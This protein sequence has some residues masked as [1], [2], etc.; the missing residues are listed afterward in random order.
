MAKR[1][2]LQQLFDAINAE[3]AHATADRADEAEVA[4]WM[5]EQGFH[6]NTWTQ[7]ITEAEEVALQSAVTA[8]E[9]RIKEIVGGDCSIYVRI[10]SDATPSD[11]SALDTPDTV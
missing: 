4:A 8:F 7:G 2:K 11:T 9:A 3:W 6:S 1:A 10:M 5:A